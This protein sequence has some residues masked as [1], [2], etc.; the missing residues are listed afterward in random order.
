[1]ETKEVSGASNV[2]SFYPI[3]SMG[4]VYL[5]TF[6][7]IYHI[8][9]LRKTNVGKYTIHGWYGMGMKLV[10]GDSSR[11]PTW[12]PIVGGHVY[13]LSKAYVNSPSQKRPPAEL[14]V[15]IFLC[16]L[17]CCFLFVCVCFFLFSALGKVIIWV[18]GS[19]RCL[20]YSEPGS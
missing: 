10:P 14:P 6:T 2:L 20:V 12:F 8:L 17:F 7:Y 9:P 16:D 3:G 5:P 19:F 1:M 18:L 13:N 11:D 15:I 4:L